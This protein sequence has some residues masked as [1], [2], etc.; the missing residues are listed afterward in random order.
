MNWKKLFADLVRL[1]VCKG[2]APDEVWENPKAFEK[3][4]EDF[5]GESIRS[6]E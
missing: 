6:H 5:F 1:A 4:Y 3:A 2:Y